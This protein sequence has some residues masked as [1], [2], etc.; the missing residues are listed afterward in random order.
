MRRVRLNSALEHVEDAVAQGFVRDERGVEAG[1]AE[2][3]LGK[4]HLDVADDVEEE[5]EGARHGLEECESQGR[6]RHPTS[7]SR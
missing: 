3:G 2:V 1:D 6:C 7:R 4:R 5:R